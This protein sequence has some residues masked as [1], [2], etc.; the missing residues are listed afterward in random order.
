LAVGL[1]YHLVQA[2]LAMA[3]LRAFE[4][5]H[6]YLCLHQ[7]PVGRLCPFHPFR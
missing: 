4:Y 3:L 5:L 7:F 2:G 1:Q 6:L